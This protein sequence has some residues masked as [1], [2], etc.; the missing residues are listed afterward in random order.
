MS[1]VLYTALPYIFVFYIL[2][3][4]TAL[5]GDGMTDFLTLGYLTFAF[6]YIMSFRKLHMDSVKMLARLRIY[7][8]C[9]LV[10]LIL[11]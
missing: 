6:Y 4:S 1:T 5:N 2:V 7:N 3:S 10:A 8:A 9:V 11:F